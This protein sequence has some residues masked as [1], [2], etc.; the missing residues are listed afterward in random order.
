MLNITIPSTGFLDKEMLLLRSIFQ[1]KSNEEG[2]SKQKIPRLA[3]TTPVMKLWKILLTNS[4]YTLEAK[5]LDYCVGAV[6]KAGS[7]RIHELLSRETSSYDPTTTL[8]G[9]NVALLEVEVD[10]VMEKILK[11]HLKS[12]KEDKIHQGVTIE[13]FATYTPECPVTAWVKWRRVA[14]V[15][16]LPTKPVFRM[17]NGACLTGALFNKHV[18][19]VLGKVINYDEKKYLSHS[20]RAGPEL[21]I[22]HKHLIMVTQFCR[23]T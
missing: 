2:V 9:C 6:A 7:F 18:K 11:I 19:S 1:G 13:L 10:G 8:L 3:M 22:F 12:P 4:K 21:S 17:S 16:L 23:Q 15:P 20:F 14:T 5:R